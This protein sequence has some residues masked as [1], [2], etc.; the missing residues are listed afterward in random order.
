MPS[1]MCFISKKHAALVESK[2]RSK[3]RLIIFG[4]TNQGA[5]VTHFR[6]YKVCIPEEKKQFG[7]T[8]LDLSL[9]RNNLM[10]II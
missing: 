3:Q 5:F 8:V 6:G 7:N 1:V 4:H 10:Q 2:K 9:K